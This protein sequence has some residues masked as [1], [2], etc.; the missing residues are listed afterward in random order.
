M[1]RSNNERIKNGARQVNLKI[2]EKSD[3]ACENQKQIY[4]KINEKNKGLDDKKDSIKEAKDKVNIEN[5]LRREEV[6]FRRENQTQI[7]VNTISE[8]AETIKMEIELSFKELNSNV[9]LLKKA[10][11]Q[12]LKNELE[13]LGRK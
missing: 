4:F 3:V 7:I 12:E 1:L 13:N 10:G 5:K 6:Q 8:S 9:V 11:V 2:E